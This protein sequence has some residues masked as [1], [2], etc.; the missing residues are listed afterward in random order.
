MVELI[1]QVSTTGRC[2]GQ[3]TVFDGRRLGALEVRTAGQQLLEPTGRSSFSGTA[4][5]CEFVGRQTGGFMLDAERST[6]EQPH[7]GTAWFAPLQPGGPMVPVRVA[8][9]TRWLGDATLY[10]AAK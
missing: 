8:F 7:T 1:R 2:D 9:R 3:E 5:R 6:L 4:L 10:L